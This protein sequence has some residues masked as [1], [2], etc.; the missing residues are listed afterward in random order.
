MGNTID[1]RRLTP[2]A[3]RSAAPGAQSRSQ[4]AQTDAFDASGGAPV[5]PTRQEASVPVPPRRGRSSA[6]RHPGHTDCKKKRSRLVE[7]EAPWNALMAIAENE[8]ACLPAA[9]IRRSSRQEA[10]VIAAV[11][12][13]VAN[14]QGFVPTAA[15]VGQAIGGIK[16]AVQFGKGQDLLQ[17][18]K[19]HGVAPEQRETAFFEHVARY[20][21]VSAAT[22]VTHT[23]VVAAIGRMQIPNASN[24]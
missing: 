11:I 4:P 6:I 15:Q 23:A 7:S 5:A 17:T 10:L 19:S 2:Y 3:T 1:G 16:R 21:Q 13:D 14:G 24:Q 9:N 12:A 8:L 22:E 20:V 18:I